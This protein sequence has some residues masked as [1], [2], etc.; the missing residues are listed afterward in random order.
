MEEVNKNESA[1]EIEVV[2][3]YSLDDEIKRVVN[4]LKKYKWYKE[5]GYKPKL[6]KNIEEKFKNDERVNFDDVSIGVS[7]EFDLSEY[8]EKVLRIQAE[9]EE[10][11]TDFFEK[12]KALNLPTQEKYFVGATVYGTGGSYFL[13]NNIQLN[14]KYYKNPSLV[15]A[16]EIVHL[17]IEP[18]IQEFNIDHWT[19]ERIV[20]L[21]MNKFF[22]DKPTMQRDP[23]NA[24]KIS[25][26]F[27]AHFPDIR[28]I[29][30]EVS[31][32]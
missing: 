11:K 1:P 16:H 25:E 32:I 24:E 12:L 7:K 19:K 13:P 22:P 28:K 27:E 6:P 8:R 15:I 20:N 18:L 5:N 4:T 31:K 29:I 21:I 10:I 23:A 9:F 26:I 2:F 30:E 17:T 14:I 3:D